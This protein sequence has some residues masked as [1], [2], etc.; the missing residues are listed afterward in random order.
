MKRSLFISLVACLLFLTQNVSQA[1]ESVSIDTEHFPDDNFRSYVLENQDKDK[2]GV[3]SEQEINTVTYLN[4]NSKNISSLKGVEYFTR[5][6]DLD[7]SINELSS[8]DISNLTNLTDLDCSNNELTSLDISNPINLTDLD[9][10][11]NELT[12]LDITEC[13]RFMYGWPK[14][15]WRSIGISCHG[16][17]SR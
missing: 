6:T 9:C 16:L 7:C 15:Q 13:W 1:A 14:Q 2:N 11:G 17:L 10:S 5:L 8:L 4:V 3:L 12:S